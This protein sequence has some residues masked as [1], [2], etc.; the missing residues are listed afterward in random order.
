MRNDTP[1]PVLITSVILSKCENLRQVCGEYRP[2]GAIAPGKTVLIL[3][4]EPLDQSKAYS[5]SYE[6][7]MVYRR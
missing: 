6:F 1:T 2:N 4:L 7:H 5:F 3:K